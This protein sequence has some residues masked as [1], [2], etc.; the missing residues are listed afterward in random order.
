MVISNL[1]AGGI[2]SLYQNQIASVKL[3]DKSVSKSGIY[4]NITIDEMINCAPLDA[5]VVAVLV[6][7]DDLLPDDSALALRKEVMA[8]LLRCKSQVGFVVMELEYSEST[9]WERAISFAEQ[10]KIAVA[11]LPPA[12]ESDMAAFDNYNRQV[13]SMYLKTLTTGSG[14]EF[15]P[16][17]N[18]AEYMIKATRGISQKTLSDDPYINYRF[19]DA[20]SVE[21]MNSL[22]NALCESIEGA[23]GGKK[24]MEAW[25]LQVE[26]SLYENVTQE[27]NVVVDSLQRDAKTVV[28]DE[29]LFTY[30]GN[31]GADDYTV[32]A[33]SFD[34]TK[35][36]DEAMSS[37]LKAHGAKW[38]AEKIVPASKFVGSEIAKCFI[39]GIEPCDLGVVPSE[40]FERTSKEL[41]KSA[42]KYFPRFGWSL[43][44]VA[45]NDENTFLDAISLMVSVAFSVAA[46]RYI[47]EVKEK[48]KLKS[49]LIATSSE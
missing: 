22:K 47:P 2:N 20:M 23:F 36:F 34:A 29:A 7:S 35:H 49:N 5:G 27:A 42:N 14:I 41:T 11:M 46:K 28:G 9:N 31:L 38:I 32:A 26:K 30:L 21:T 8:S 40:L 13:V 33:F 17:S 45:N 39:S 19:S 3:G 43:I 10:L 15:I 48:S 25:V 1:N 16:A 44:E 24:A 4:L 18:Y 37:M 6:T 12:P